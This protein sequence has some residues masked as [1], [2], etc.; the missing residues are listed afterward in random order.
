MAD[1]ADVPPAD[2]ARSLAE[3]E[4]EVAELRAR[5]G[6]AEALAGVGSWRF[7]LNTRLVDASAEARRIYGL[8]DD[9]WTI[10]HVQGI[11]LPEYRPM[12]DRALRDL[13]EHGTPYDV[14]FRIRRP[15]D[16]AVRHIHSMAD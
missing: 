15:S 1:A 10:P 2:L 6:V 11:P 8:G 4:R 9:E 3:L 14:E 5:R 13:I 12:L 16:H 7:D